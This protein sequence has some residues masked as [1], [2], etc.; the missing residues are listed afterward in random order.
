MLFLIRYDR[1]KGRIVLL[2]K[3]EE[4]QK[5]TAERQRLELELDLNRKG[6]RDEIVLL[7][8]PSED[9]LRVTHRRYFQTAQEIAT[10][11][12]PSRREP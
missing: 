6:V 3:F 7:E 2:E 12:P 8:A 1:R 4:Q 5:T 11:D 10:S 9:A